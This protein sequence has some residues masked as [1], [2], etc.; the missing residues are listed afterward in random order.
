MLGW[1]AW[2]EIEAEYGLGLLV[3][4]HTEARKTDLLIDI[5]VRALAQLVLSA[6]R[7]AA[8]MIA[9]ADAPD[10]VRAETQQVLATWTGG[11][12]PNAT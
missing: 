1:D 9:E 12:D 8:R 4:T 5:P 11:P 10:Q 6:V 3:E 2:R 7:E